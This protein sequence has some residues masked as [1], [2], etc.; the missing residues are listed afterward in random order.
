MMRKKI[1]ALLLVFVLL[2]TIASCGGATGKLKSVQSTGKIVVYTDPNF[3]PFEFIGANQTPVGVDME[4]ARAIAGE[5]GV[6]LEIQEADFDSITTAIKGGRGDIA[7]SGFTITEERKQSVD[8]SRP[9][10]NSVQYLILM[11][12]DGTISTMESL[13]GLNIGVAKG[14]SGQ[15]WIEDEMDEG[16]ALY[17]TGVS[18]MEYNNAMDATLDLR[19]GRINAVVMDEYVA[20]SIVSAGTGLKTIPLQYEDGELAAEEYGVLVAKGN[21]DLLRI[22]NSVLDKLIADGK[23]AE[24]VVSFSEQ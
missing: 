13:A 17:G 12:S 6:S 9:Y 2:M 23:I 14:Y 4:I 3:P 16:G 24:W 5:L 22:I 10:I 18:V 8:F 15:F 1:V 7:V 20:K 11:E 19:A 21:D